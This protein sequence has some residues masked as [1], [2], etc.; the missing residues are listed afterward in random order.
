MEEI[1]ELVKAD[2][3]SSNQILETNQPQKVLSEEDL[4]IRLWVLQQTLDGSGFSKEKIQQV[5]KYILDISTRVSVPNKDA[6]WGLEEA[7]DWLARECSKGDLPD[8]DK[9]QRKGGPG[10]VSRSQLGKRSHSAVLK[11]LILIF[12]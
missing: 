11:R 4:T 5:I 12:P 3:R 6:I 10:H 1:L 9:L 8:Y 7:L 2:G